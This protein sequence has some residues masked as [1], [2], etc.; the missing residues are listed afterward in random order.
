MDNI[1]N[2]SMTI[3][4]GVPVEFNFGGA[5]FSEI[6]KIIVLVVKKIKII[7]FFNYNL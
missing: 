7:L 5:F 4:G 2:S 1:E 6:Q 3:N